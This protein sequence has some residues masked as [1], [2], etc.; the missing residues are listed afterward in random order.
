MH[1]IEQQHLHEEV[2]LCQGEESVNGCEVVR[3][4]R[5]PLCALCVHG[6]LLSP[7]HLPE[8]M[9]RQL[10]ILVPARQAH[11][12]LLDS[13]DV[14]TA[15]QKCWTVMWLASS[16]CGAPVHLEHVSSSL[17]YSE[18]THHILPAVPAMLLK[19]LRP[20]STQCATETIDTRGHHYTLQGLW[21]QRA[22][23]CHTSQKRT[24]SALSGSRSS[25][26][27]W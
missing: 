21:L 7:C 5:V 19:H 13:W 12:S 25:L 4:E 24:N 1:A 23:K 16:G 11:H 17:V 3:I 2:G 10:H 15:R 14:R 8:A 27:V 18:S 6:L 26:S 20:E 22:L 9:E